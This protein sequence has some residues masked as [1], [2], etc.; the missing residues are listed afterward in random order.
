MVKQQ[1]AKFRSNF[2]KTAIVD[3]L[4][5]LLSFNPYFR[6]TPLEI[7]KNPLFDEVRDKNK[8][9]GLLKM[10]QSK[11][12][13]IELDIDQMAAFDYEDASKAKYS[14]EQLTTIL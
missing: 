2:K 11:T 3:I 13:L 8:E 12:P 4:E 6:M 9:A 14:V 10:Q 1:L 7:A 5:N